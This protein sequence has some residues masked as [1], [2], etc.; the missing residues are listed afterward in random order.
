[1]PRVILFV[2]A[3][4]QANMNLQLPFIMRILADHP[5][6]EY[7]IWNLCRD[8]SD[9]AFLRTIVGK[10]MI[11]RDDYYEEQPGWNQVYRHY[12]DKEYRG[13]L[14]VKLDDDVVFLET[15]RFGAFLDAITAHP[16]AILSAN[17]VN[18]G[19]CTALVPGLW[20]RFAALDI[21]LLDVHQ[22]NAYSEICHQH[23]LQY[24]ELIL[25]QEVE[26]I[27]TKDWLSINVI[28]YDWAMN[29]RMSTKLDKPHPPVIAGRTF[30]RHWRMGDEGCVNTFPR[31]VMRGFTAGHL[32]FGPQ[33]PTVSQLRR[34]RRGY[35][36][37][38][39]RYLQDQR[40]SYASI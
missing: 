33:H 18:N 23:F 11:V 13:C 29:N 28:G 9:V 39:R 16:Q 32:T 10:R 8:P 7:H 2:F 26:L 1:M 12:T 17:V 30:P 35:A 5:N 37:L 31:M 21:P 38:G 14:F 36:E 4:R 6:V 19:A 15:A 20:D 40:V 22:S 3:G 34:W 27:R 24:R 25:G